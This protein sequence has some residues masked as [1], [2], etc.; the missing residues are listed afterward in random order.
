M[1]GDEPVE[2]REFGNDVVGAAP[3]QTGAAVDEDFLGSQP[4]DAAG[5]AEAT[6]WTRQ[7]AQA[8][9][10][11]RP[12]AAFFGEPVVVVRFGIVDIAAGAFA[13]AVGVIEI[14]RDVA[15]G[16]ILEQLGVGPLHAA[17]GEQT[18]RGLP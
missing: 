15:T 12:C 14:P 5:E 7:R 9:P 2:A 11:Q 4:F 18:F 13:L 10:Q 16:I 17:F 1:I 6:A 3:I 8:I